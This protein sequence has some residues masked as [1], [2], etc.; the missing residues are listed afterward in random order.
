MDRMRRTEWKPW[1]KSH[2]RA[3]TAV[4]VSPTTALV[5][6]WIGG[7]MVGISLVGFAG[8]FWSAFRDEPHSVTG[9]ESLDLPGALQGAVAH[10]GYA[11]PTRT[12]V[13][14]VPRENVALP[15]DWEAVVLRRYRE[16]SPDQPD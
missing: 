16:R 8:L 11:E 5:C 9:T 7:V 1:P 13:V 6:E 3:M 12:V 2:D 14:Q 10:H 4:S 15:D